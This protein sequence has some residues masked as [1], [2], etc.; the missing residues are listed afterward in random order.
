MRYYQSTNSCYVSFLMVLG[1][2][3]LASGC[4]SHAL[5]ADSFDHD[6]YFGMRANADVVHLQQFLAE[7]GLYQGPTNGN[8][9]SLTRTAV[10]QFQKKNAIA[11]AAGYVGPKTRDV[12]NAKLS[13]T[14]VVDRAAQI[15]AIQDQI[16]TLLTQI[17]S[18]QS[19]ASAMPQPPLSPYEIEL[20][21]EMDK[22]ILPLVPASTTVASSTP[23]ALPNP[24][25][26][27]LRVQTTA[28]PRSVSSYTDVLLHEFRFTADE[29]IAIEKL[30][31]VNNGTLLDY[32]V[33]NIRLINSTTGQIIARLDAPVSGVSEFIMNV[34][35]AKPNKGLVVSGELYAIICDILTP[36]YGAVRPTIQLNLQTAADIAAFD[37][38]DLSRVATIKQ[39]TF[40]VEGPKLTF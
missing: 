3:A 13:G 24:F 14:S 7:A 1:I 31:F 21:L 11:P 8:F 17:A 9:F 35:S 39:I 12:I 18:L 10:I 4:V 28:F 33:R 26:S 2:F 40:P 34:D 6:L 16:Q 15:K 23:S 29:K 37:Y 30:R 19:N 27:T 36:N 5:A 22:Q 20:T 38:G 32:Y 25:D